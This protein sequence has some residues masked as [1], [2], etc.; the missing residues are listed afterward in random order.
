MSRGG[1]RCNSTR[2]PQRDTHVDQRSL[3]PNTSSGS[4]RMAGTQG[5]GG[6]TP[7]T[8]DIVTPGDRLELEL[9]E[10]QYVMALRL[11][12][13]MRARQRQGFDLFESPR[14]TSSP[15]RRS[16][17]SSRAPSGPPTVP[18]TTTQKEGSQP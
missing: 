6:S 13:T 10:I 2:T 12:A 15:D 1:A 4:P 9:R 18:A 11:G 3:E 17:V 16:P 7:F 14:S 8:L 5:I